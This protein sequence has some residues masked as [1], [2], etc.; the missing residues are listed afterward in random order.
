MMERPRFEVAD[1][2]RLYGDGY[3]QAHGS[4]MSLDQLRIMRDIE[5]CR[6]A[7][8][9]G[10]VDACEECGVIQI[11]YNSC[12]N[13][14]C[15]KCQSLAKTRWLKARLEELLPVEYFHVVFTVPDPVAAI[16]LQNKRTVYN[17]L[18][19]TAAQTLRM[20]AADPKHLGADIGF[21]AVLH[22]WG[23]NMLLHPHLHFIVPGGGFDHSGQRWVSC[24]PGFLLPVRVLSRLFRRLFL[25][26]LDKA[27]QKGELE[28]HGSLV[29]LS[30]RERFD[31]WLKPARQT[32]WVVY[33]KK[34]FGGPEKVLDYLGRYT[35]RVAIS[36]HRIL[37]VGNGKVT[38]SWRDYRH[39]N[40]KRTMTLK[41]DEFIRRFFLHTL[42]KG[43]VRIRQYGFLANR[44]RAAKL[45]RARELLQV[46]KPIDEA[47]SEDWRDLYQ[48]LTG[49]DPT[50]CPI[51][52]KG[53]LVCI[54]T[55]DPEP[56]P[57]WAP[58]TIDS[59]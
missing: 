57:V 32:E 19:R 48:Q 5:T 31:V 14:H 12:C 25:E 10:H 17:I 58:E 37:K 22:S 16:A 46:P 13:R 24:R 49:T 1:V 42:P 54:E 18:F 4:S 39:G 51:C 27:F 44:Q 3:R 11:S 34:P 9:G 26:A 7:A 59:S 23:Q 8:L 2:F 28:F 53:Q 45:E 21:I 29:E 55:L 52:G 20:I 43:F 36:N 40:R 47:V 38:F 35:H 50:L 6:T 30:A 41:A 33:S 15:P 56:A